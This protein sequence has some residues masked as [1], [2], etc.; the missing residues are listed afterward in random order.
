MRTGDTVRDGQG[1]AYQVGQQLGRGLWGKSFL[2]RRETNDQL[3]VLKVPLT[4]DDLRGEGGAPEAFFAACRDALME[5]ARLYEQGQLPFLPRLEARFTA[6]DGQPA[7]LLPRLAESLERR[8]QDGLPLSGLIDVLLVV[9]KHVRQLA[10]SGVS[11]APA[12]GSLRATNILFSERGEVFLTDVATPAVRRNLGA[13]SGLAPGGNPWAP[14][15]YASATTEPIWSPVVDT[16]AM[17]MLLWRG[18][19]GPEAPIAWPTRGLDKGAVSSVKDRL[20]ERMKAEDSN[21]RFHSRLAERVGVLLS[22]ALSLE[23]APSPPFRFTRLEEFVQRLEEIA[24]LIRPQVTNVGKVLHDRPAA[25]P[26]FDTDEAVAFSVTVGATAGVEG[27]EEIGVGIAVFDLAKDTRVKDLDLGYTVDK[28]PSGR[29]RFAFRVSGLSPGPYRAKVAFAIRDSGQPPAAAETEFDIRAAPGWV[30]PAEA[31]PTAALPFQREPTQVTQPR[32]DVEPPSR[33]IPPPVAPPPA[34][35]APPVRE[36]ALREPP[37]PVA[38]PPEPPPEPA[39]PPVQRP[40]AMRTPAQAA[41][42]SAR[43]RPVYPAPMQVSPP[44]PALAPLATPPAAP[45]PVAPAMPPVNR[46]RPLLPA[47]MEPEPPRPAPQLAPPP[48]APPVAAPIATPLPP[49]PAAMGGPSAPEEPAFEAPKNWTYEPIPRARSAAQPE[50]PPSQVDLEPDDDG[51][52]GLVQKLAGAITKDPFV[53]V[54]TSLGALIALLL[55][56][57]LAI[58]S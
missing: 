37:R 6:P 49:T 13:F 19:V 54:M 1:N 35:T 50:D 7:V 30:P 14:P 44:E 57:Y 17:A 8:I 18:I 24:A 41:E 43:P 2:A 23:V 38:G 52:P 11:G 46:P 22:R 40:T 3:F 53:L 27:R 28:H 26:W 34:P 29:Y 47:G 36:P 16:W 33:I 5:E 10:S 4:A 45:D 25:K 9:A 20:I 21:P 48:A 56:V 51:E 42:P 39:L 15:E 58:R 12:H 32:V 55:L 31:P